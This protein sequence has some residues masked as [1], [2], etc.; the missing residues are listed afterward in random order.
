[1]QTNHPKTLVQLYRAFYRAK[2]NK[3][4]LSSRA[5]TRPLKIALDLLIKEYQATP[6]ELKDFIAASLMKLMQ[7]I[8]FSTA[9]GYAVTGGVAEIEAIKEFARYLVDDYFVGSL[10][11]DRSRIVGNKGA[12]LLHT[13]EFIYRELERGE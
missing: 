10:N 6:L 13:C 11:S 1:M 2:P 9:E 3:G 8:H 5:C 7:Q 4:K 12:L